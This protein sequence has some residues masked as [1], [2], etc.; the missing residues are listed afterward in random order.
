M[1]CV[2]L[3]PLALIRRIAG[4]QVDTKNSAANDLAASPKRSRLILNLLKD[5]GAVEGRFARSCP[6]LNGASANPVEQT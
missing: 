2:G 1:N 3:A 4:A 5:G 6:F